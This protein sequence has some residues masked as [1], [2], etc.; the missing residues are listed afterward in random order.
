MDA[1]K[2]FE[3]DF[4]SCLF[5]LNTNLLL[6]RHHEAALKAYVTKVLSDDPLN[7]SDSFLAQTRVHAAKPRNHLRRT[8]LL[9]PVASWFLYDLVARNNMV[10]GKN[11][12]PHRRSFGYTISNKGPVPVSKAYRDFLSEIEKD[13]EKYKHRLSFDIASYF[14]SIYHHD[15]AH[16]F[17]ALP[18]ISGARR[19]CF[20]ALLSGN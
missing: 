20:W 16:W 14:N 13:K 15:A 19:G 3:N 4:G 12:K 18:G 11:V 17:G 5:P 1:K 7:K 2:F 6:I 9:D 8:V 10:F